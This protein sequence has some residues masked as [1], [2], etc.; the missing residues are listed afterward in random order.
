[1]TLFNLNISCW[2]PLHVFKNGKTS[3]L[4]S[5]GQVIHYNKRDYRIDQT[6]ITIYIY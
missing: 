1:M 2:L 4:A 6:R 5:D 3:I